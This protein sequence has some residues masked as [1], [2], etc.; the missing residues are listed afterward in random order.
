VRSGP[1]TP[2]KKSTALQKSPSAPHKKIPVYPSNAATSE[3]PI[4]KELK[5]ASVKKIDSQV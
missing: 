2:F 5:R 4:A 3:G 1:D